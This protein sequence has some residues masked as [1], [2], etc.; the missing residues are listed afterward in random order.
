MGN[1]AP[2]SKCNN[3]YGYW[4]LNQTTGSAAN[5]DGTAINP[6]LFANALP[7]KRQLYTSMWSVIP[8]TFF[9]NQ[10]YQ[11]VKPL[12]HPPPQ[13]PLQFSDEQ[14]TTMTGQNAIPA[15]QWNGTN[16]SQ[17]DYLNWDFANMQISRIYNYQF[18]EHDVGPIACTEVNGTKSVDELLTCHEDS[19][20]TAQ[21]SNI[22]YV[23]EIC[24]PLVDSGSA[25]I[26]SFFD[27]YFKYKYAEVNDIPLTDTIILFQNSS[28]LSFSTGSSNSGTAYEYTTLVTGEDNN[29]NCRAS[30]PYHIWVSPNPNGIQTYSCNKMLWNP[31]NIQDCCTE[32]G[33]DWSDPLTTIQ[34]GLKCHPDWL[35][36]SPTCLALYQD[37]CGWFAP[38]SENPTEMNAYST[39]NISSDGTISPQSQ[40]DSVIDCG[41]WTNSLL[42]S[43]TNAYQT[44]TQN[45]KPT[46]AS[47]IVQEQLVYAAISAVNPPNNITTI[48]RISGYTNSVLDLCKFSLDNVT[49]PITLYKLT[50]NA[51]KLKLVVHPPIPGTPVNNYS[52]SWSVP[53][54]TT[55]TIESDNITLDW[56]GGVNLTSQSVN[57]YVLDFNQANIT[58]NL[59]HQYNEL[60]LNITSNTIPCN[61]HVIY[62]AKTD[63]VPSLVDVPPGD[64]YFDIVDV[65]NNN[66]IMAT[67][68]VHYNVLNTVTFP[69]QTGLV[70]QQK[71]FRCYVSGYNIIRKF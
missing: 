61:S 49:T 29:E 27:T 16:Y 32:F 67:Y 36:G 38:A 19:S 17:E 51:M 69:Y 35:P 70:F 55:A 6:N 42:G 63:I 31:Y 47:N 62:S 46:L 8:E 59:T 30:M 56:T 1:S 18:H 3:R 40:S 71:G 44:T 24:P 13:P 45:G 54:G 22:I 21:N 43:T 10:N 15:T 66:K 58:H 64:L 60:A 25:S 39:V 52:V 53:S 68:V 20:P 5:P 4:D 37:I 34:L 23:P 28:N 65:N 50:N 14:S 11:T 48:P 7:K 2:N 26:V 12:L 57:I 41:A 9:G 33:S